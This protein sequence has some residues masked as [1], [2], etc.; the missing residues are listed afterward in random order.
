MTDRSV[1]AVARLLIDTLA[2]ML[3]SVCNRHAAHEIAETVRNLICGMSQDIVVSVRIAASQHEAVRAALAHLPA[4]MARRIVLVAVDIMPEGDAT[5]EWAQGA[6]SHSP[7]RARQA[8]L[9]ILE[10]LHLIE[11]QQQQVSKTPNTEWQPA[12]PEEVS[13]A[14]IGETI[15]A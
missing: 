4:Q 2:A 13:K 7:K 1:E 8:A 12:M 10:R 9:E 6:A 5:L 3:P 15:D 14:K 11:P